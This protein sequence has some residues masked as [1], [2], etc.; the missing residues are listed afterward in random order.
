MP[1]T[2]LRTLDELDAIRH[3]WSFNLY[4][5]EMAINHDEIFSALR[6]ALAVVEE[7]GKFDDKGDWMGFPR[8]RTAI[9]RKHGFETVIE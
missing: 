7:L 1:N 2:I 3:D 8:W 9:L 6:R 5:V 4:M